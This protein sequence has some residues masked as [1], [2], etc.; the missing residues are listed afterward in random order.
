M[1]SHLNQPV[2]R[3]AVYTGSFDPITLGHQNLIERASRIVDELIVGVGLYI[4]KQSL[5]TAEERVGLIQ[6]AVQHLP[7]VRVQP[8][9]GL[10]VRFVRDCGAGVII[11]GVRSLSDM[12]SEFTMSLANRKLD[13]DPRSRKADKLPV[14][15]ASRAN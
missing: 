1:S 2:K 14:G 3:I 15:G 6:S 4:E 9:A 13:D 8:F 5:F 7:N 11:R 12:E 10:A